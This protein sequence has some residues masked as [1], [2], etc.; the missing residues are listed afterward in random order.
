MQ[1]AEAAHK[2]QNDADI[3]KL[4]QGLLGQNSLPESEADI[5]RQSF[6][7]SAAKIRKHR[8]PSHL[9]GEF[10]EAMESDDGDTRASEKDNGIK[11]LANVDEQQRHNRS[12]SALT[13]HLKSRE[14]KAEKPPPE[15]PWLTQ[16]SQKYGRR[17]SKYNEAIDVILDTPISG[18][19]HNATPEGE[20]YGNK[21]LECYSKSPQR[22]ESDRSNNES[23][24]EDDTHTPILL[25]NHDLVRRA[26]AGDEVVEAFEEDKLKTIE[27]EGDRI[28]DNT[29]PGWGN[30]TGE[31]I[32]RKQ[33]KRQKRFLT[34]IEGVK[35]EQR[36]D[37][38]LARVIINEKRVK[39]VS[40]ECLPLESIDASSANLVIEHKVPSNTVAS[41]F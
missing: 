4:R 29:L 33:V 10:E 8:P 18:S 22:S 41:P 26:F 6:G 14:R 24:S 1:N 37:A 32:S 7:R 38:K 31:G 12:Q 17:G 19:H 39:K 21:T 5:G 30:W 25:K 36:K 28:I 15:N 11:V 3:E 23:A 27:E 35:P 9:E 34:A 2:L 16:N 40:L 20:P 13:N